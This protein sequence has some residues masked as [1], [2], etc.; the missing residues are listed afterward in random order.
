MELNAKHYQAIEGMS[1]GKS[2]TDIALSLGVT[3]KTLYAWIDDIDFK[4]E[5]N[6]LLEANRHSN[7]EFLRSLT[8]K[9]LTTIESIMTDEASPAKDRLNAAIKVLELTHLKAPEIGETSAKKLKKQRLQDE[10]L[11]DLF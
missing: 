6:V 7:Q 9:A 11:Y 4:A 2:K 3:R 1:A 10:A 5:L 8:T